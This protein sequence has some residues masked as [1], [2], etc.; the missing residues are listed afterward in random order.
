VRVLAANLFLILFGLSI[1]VTYFSI[2]MGWLRALVAGLSGW[3]ASSV[4]LF[5]YSFLKGDGI[6]QALTVALSLGF[7]FTLTSVSIGA[8]FHANAGVRIEKRDK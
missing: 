8:F 2:R 7:L 1:A 6:S 5:F 4:F 3:V